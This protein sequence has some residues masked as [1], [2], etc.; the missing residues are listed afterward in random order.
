MGRAIFAEGNILVTNSTQTLVLDDHS[1]AVVASWPYVV[2]AATAGRGTATIE[3]GTSMTT[4]VVRNADGE[5]QPTTTLDGEARPLEGG[6]WIS[7]VPQGSSAALKGVVGPNI[8][9]ANTGRPMVNMMRPPGLINFS[10]RPIFVKDSA[11]EIRVQ[12]VEPYSFGSWDHI[13]SRPIDGFKPGIYDGDWHKVSDW[14]RAIVNADDT[15]SVFG[16]GSMVPV[17]D[18]SR[19]DMLNGTPRPELWKYTRLPG[20]KAEPEW[21]LDTDKCGVVNGLPAG[22]CG[23]GKI[24]WG[25]NHIPNCGSGGYLEKARR[26]L[27]GVLE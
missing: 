17:V 19:Y 4:V 9:F 13:Y 21:S 7:A 25:V 5:T 2:S 10:S 3:S 6:V 18:R 20:R 22:L 11:C 23:L 12:T 16:G 8:T 14:T 15:F 27:Q 24:D 1:G 26:F